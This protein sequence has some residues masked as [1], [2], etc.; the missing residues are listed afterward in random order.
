MNANQGTAEAMPNFEFNISDAVMP[1]AVAVLT[2]G[3]WVVGFLVGGSLVKAGWNL[4]RPRPETIRV[5]LKP[6]QLEH[7]ATAEVIPP[8]SAPPPPA[9]PPAAPPPPDT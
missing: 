2:F 7:G 6:Q 9:A 1:V 4:I 5:R 3:M 8:A